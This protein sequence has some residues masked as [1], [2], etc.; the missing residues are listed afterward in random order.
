[1]KKER[2]YII[3]EGRVQGVGFR[4]FCAEAARAYGV[5]G[6]VRNLVDG[7]VEILG[8]GVPQQLGKFATAC[9]TG[10]S[11]ARVLKVEEEYSKA[12]GA[13]DSFSIRS[14]GFL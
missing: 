11:T 5:V 2:V 14:S 9:K 13:F 10:P 4:Y 1:M 6:W 3:V 8:E 7:R 12:S